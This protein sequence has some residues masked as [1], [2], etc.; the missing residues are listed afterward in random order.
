MHS[1]QEALVLP[2]RSKSPFMVSREVKRRQEIQ[3]DGLEALYGVLS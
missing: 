2:D 1:R 3:V